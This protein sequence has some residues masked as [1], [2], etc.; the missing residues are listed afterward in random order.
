MLARQPWLLLLKYSALLLL[1]GSFEAEIDDISRVI[2]PCLLTILTRHSGDRGS[3]AA[4][5]TLDG[6]DWGYSSRFCGKC[7]QFQLLLV[8]RSL[9][10]VR[11]RKVDIGERIS[12]TR[13]ALAC[14]LL[15]NRQ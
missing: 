13:E 6:R 15:R 11:T 2:E 8:F 9:R 10:C 1:E 14:G 3:P 4:S 5:P 7:S 12:L